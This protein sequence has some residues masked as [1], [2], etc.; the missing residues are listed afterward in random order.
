MEQQRIQWADLYAK[1]QVSVPAGEGPDLALIHAVEVPHFGED[2]V[3]EPVDEATLAA[4]GF[5]GEDYLPA[6]WQGGAYQ[7][8][9]YAIPLDVPQHIFYFNVKVMREAGLVGS[10][11]FGLGNVYW[12]GM[13]HTTGCLSRRGTGATVNSTLASRSPVK[14]HEPA[15]HIPSFPARNASRGFALAGGATLC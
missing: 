7:G 10:T 1:L 11:A 2:G 9:R 8:K 13:V 4:K 6:I 3:L 12:W 14:F 15:S 5:K